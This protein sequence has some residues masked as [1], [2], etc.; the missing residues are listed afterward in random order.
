M[1]G[2]GFLEIPTPE[3]IHC[4]LP[5]NMFPVSFRRLRWQ[6]RS[7]AMF[8]LDKSAMQLSKRPTELL[9]GKEELLKQLQASL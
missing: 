5:A 1:P 8:V 2:I 6:F 3:G 9:T 4:L 7:Y